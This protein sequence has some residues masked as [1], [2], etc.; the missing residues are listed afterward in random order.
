[1]P[2]VTYSILMRVWPCMLEMCE[3]SNVTAAGCCF[4]LALV[5][6]DLVANFQTHLCKLPQSLVLSGHD[7][8]VRMQ[9]RLILQ[10]I[11]PSVRPSA[12]LCK[13]EAKQDIVHDCTVQSQCSHSAVWRELC[14][15]IDTPPHSANQSRR[16]RY[17]GSC[18][19]S[20]QSDFR[21]KIKLEVEQKEFMSARFNT[22][23]IWNMIFLF[24]KI[25]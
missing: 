17:S 14:P 4:Q 22:K 9:L 21:R 13:H 6:S 2:S 1:M 23:T 3:C 5:S 10:S 24:Q 25:L 15:V 18:V 12:C 11:H 19:H 20:V 16:V 7:P 8:A